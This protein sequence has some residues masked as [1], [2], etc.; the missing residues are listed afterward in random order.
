[1]AVIIDNGQAH[2]VIV[3]RR[4]T[5]ASIT[6]VLQPLKVASPGPQGRDGAPGPSGAGYT[7]TQSVAST[8]WT[9]NHNLGYRPSVELIDAGGNEFS[10]EVAHPSLNTAVVTI[11]VAVAGTARLN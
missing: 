4:N 11:K 6:K 2:T 9:I 1:M 5:V 3:E 10:A 8:T 7:H